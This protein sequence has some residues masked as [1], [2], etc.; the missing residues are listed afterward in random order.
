[1]PKEKMY[2]NSKFILFILTLIAIFF[3]IILIAIFHNDS[4]INSKNLSLPNIETYCYNDSHFEIGYYFEHYLINCNITLSSA[5]G[6][7]WIY[8]FCLENNQ[9]DDYNDYYY[10][11]SDVCYYKNNDV[12][13]KRENYTIDKVKRIPIYSTKEICK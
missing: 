13:V 4:L 3:F 2:S 1:M 8:Q 10:C 7:G 6:D 5:L 11:P 9:T 12:R